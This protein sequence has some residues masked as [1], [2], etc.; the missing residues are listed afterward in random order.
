MLAFIPAGLGIKMYME[1]N[2]RDAQTIVSS[3]YLTYLCTFLIVPSY[4]TSFLR[5]C[6][7]QVCQCFFAFKAGILN[8]TYYNM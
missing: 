1:I 8:H 6:F 2:V 4:P 7:R 5:S 3:S